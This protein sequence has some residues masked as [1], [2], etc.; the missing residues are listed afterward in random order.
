MWSVSFYVVKLVAMSRRIVYG[1]LFD[2]CNVAKL[3]GSPVLYKFYQFMI[4]WDQYC[5]LILYTF[6]KFVVKLFKFKTRI[7]FK[8]KIQE[9]T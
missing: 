8:K 3:L 9:I 7:D 4:S 1:I 6:C 5:N 2:F